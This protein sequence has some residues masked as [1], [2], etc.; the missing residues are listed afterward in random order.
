MVPF[1]A[2][3]KEKEK[4]ELSFL[5][6]RKSPKS[7]AEQFAGYF[8]RAHDC[9]PQLG[10]GLFFLTKSV[11]SFLL[12]IEEKKAKEDQGGFGRQRILAGYMQLG[13]NLFVAF[14]APGQLGKRP[15]VT[16]K[17]PG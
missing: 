8:F 10:R 14:E 13:K 1:F 2:S 4:E 7:R 15:F 16:F 12:L 9:L 17:V 5:A 11:P 6:S 3:R